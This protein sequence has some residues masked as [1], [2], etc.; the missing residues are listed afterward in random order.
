ME[1]IWLVN[2]YGPIEGENWREYSFNQFGKYLSSKGYSVVWWTASFSHH[3]KKYRSKGW[4][5]ISVNKNF[6][7]RLVPTSSYSKNFGIGRMYKDLVFGEK[8]LKRFRQEERPDLIL[9]AENPLTM[10]RPC[11]LY[12]RK[13]NVPL[14]YDQMD[15]WPEFIVNSLKKPL[16]SIAQFFL[17]PVYIRRK[18]IYDSLSGSIALGK[19]YL[20]FMQEVSP[21]LK[22]KPNALVYNGIDV[23]EF[24]SHLNDNIS[25]KGIPEKIIGEIWCVFAGTLG[26]SYDIE[27]IIECAGRCKRHGHKEYK[28]IVAG[29]GPLEGIMVNAANKLDNL[30]YI[31]KLLPEQLIPIY[32]KCD[33]GLATYSS[34]SN[35]DMC[36]KFYDYTAAGLAVINSLTGEISEHIEQRRIGFNY[37]ANNVESF[38]NVL[39]KF[40]N[41]NILHEAKNNSLAV[42]DIFDKNVQNDKML[43]VIESILESGGGGNPN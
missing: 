34:G 26:P 10:G 18:A 40:K 16:S 39:L 31:G 21:S 3:F 33:I 13:Y 7:I 43:K 5:D 29:S 1:R 22:E 20:E 23:N 11:F 42:G 37:K 41:K 2:P 15:I 24:R 14:I 28:F 38:M 8:A 17:K 25:V 35:V 9:A 4:K 36:D 27:G 32:G 12:A 19:H 6:V 30:F